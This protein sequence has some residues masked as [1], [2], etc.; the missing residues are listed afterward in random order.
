[1]AP[2]ERLIKATAKIVMTGD[3]KVGSTIELTNADNAGVTHWRWQ[4]YPP[5][6]SAATLRDLTGHKTSFKIDV[7]G[8]YGVRLMVNDGRPGLD[9]W[10]EIEVAGD[11]FAT[12]LRLLEKA[13]YPGFVIAALTPAGGTAICA[14][15]TTAKLRARVDEQMALQDSGAASDDGEDRPSTAVAQLRELA[16]WLSRDGKD[17]VSGLAADLAE[18]IAIAYGVE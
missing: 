6:G 8:K 2:V 10:C 5:E 11:P 1:M 3:P 17:D 18:S 4:F 9:V 15:N 12:A 16:A 7:A 14:R 13:D